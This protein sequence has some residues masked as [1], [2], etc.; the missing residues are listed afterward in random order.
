VTLSPRQNDSDDNPPSKRALGYGVGATSV[1][2]GTIIAA[3]GT[4]GV[5]S[6]TIR[7]AIVVFGILT[8]LSLVLG[9][10]AAWRGGSG[11][12]ESSDAGVVDDGL[13]APRRSTLEERPQSAAGYDDDAR[14]GAREEPD[15]GRNTG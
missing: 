6:G 9:L 3:G 2:I 14:Q 1:A 11:G 15:G 12:K 13:P 7:L 5:D 10:L 4:S 8:T